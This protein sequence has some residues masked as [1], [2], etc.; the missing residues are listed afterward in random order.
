MSDKAQATDDPY[1]CKSGMTTGVTCTRIKKI[2]YD[3]YSEFG[4]VYHNLNCGKHNSAGGDSGA[5]TFSAVPQRR[6][7]AAAVGVH[8]GAMV[9][10]H[11]RTGEIKEII[12]CWHTAAAVEKHLGAKIYRPGYS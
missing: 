7:A 2:A 11:H 10:R 12:T 1:V 5:P 6:R 8:V 4:T 9:R 3:A